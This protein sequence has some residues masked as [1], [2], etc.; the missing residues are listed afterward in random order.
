MRNEQDQYYLIREHQVGKRENG[1]YF[2]YGKNGWEPDTKC[3]IMDRLMGYDPSE[4]QGSP[5]G[6]GCTSIMDEI[7]EISEDRAMEITGEKA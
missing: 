4:P 2:L 3:M 7:E 5:Y 1:Y 6:I